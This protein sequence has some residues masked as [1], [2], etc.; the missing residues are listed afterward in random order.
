M[1][2]NVRTKD[3]LRDLLRNRHSG[4]WTIGQNSERRITKVRVFNWDA[5]QV[6]KGDYNPKSSSW[7]SNKD[8]IIGII[9]SR[10]ENFKFDSTWPKTFGAAVVVYTEDVCIQ[11]REGEKVGIVRNTYAGDIST[12][13]INDYFE[14]LLRE[15]K[16]RGLQKIVFKAG[17]IPIPDS[18]KNWCLENNVIIQILDDNE[19][20]RI[21]PTELD[22]FW[23]DE[24]FENDNQNFRD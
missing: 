12:S 2:V 24:L 23:E 4:N 1:I 7:D 13:E 22:V 8:L 11:V 20:I 9:K 5:N 15:I 6:L 14:R 3:D 10:I 21:Y 19:L 16:M 17:C 18:F